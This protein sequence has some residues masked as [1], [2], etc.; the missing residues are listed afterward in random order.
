MGG[1]TNGL[2]F[3]TVARSWAI[4]SQAA[5]ARLFSAMAWSSRHKTAGLSLGGQ[6]PGIQ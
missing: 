5:A 3:S 1:G 6:G 2:D 4:L